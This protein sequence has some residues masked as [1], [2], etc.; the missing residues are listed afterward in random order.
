MKV[1]GKQLTDEA[2]L[3]LQS[4][5]TH[6]FENAAN[7]MSTMLGEALTVSHPEVDKFSLVQ[8]S[9]FMGD[10]ETEAVGI[11]LRSEGDLGVQMMLVIPYQK[12]LELVDMLMGQEIGTTDKMGSLER[13]ALGEIG[14]ITGTFFLNSI[15]SMT[16]LT[17]K[18]TPP[19]VVVDMLAAVLDIIIA[20]T[21]ESIEEML[22]LKVQISNG[23]RDM[24]VSFWVIPDS[25]ILNYVMRKFE[26][27][28]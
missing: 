20:T 13:S 19:A 22:L 24:N 26:A 14:N 9:Q 16:D 5:I 11:Y 17:I 28:E 25:Q 7:G 15:A 2:L 8:M 4:L 3:R 27:N 10:P 12:A 21:G 1:A 23:S 18:P 6:G